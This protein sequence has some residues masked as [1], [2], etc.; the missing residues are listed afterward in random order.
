MNP[1]VFLWL[2]DRTLYFY[3]GFFRFSEVI[4]LRVLSKEV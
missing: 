2:L 3:K 1:S 4:I